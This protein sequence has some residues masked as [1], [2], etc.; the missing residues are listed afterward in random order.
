MGANESNNFYNLEQLKSIP[1]LDVCNVFGIVV[2]RKGGQLWC[3][4]RPER[5]ASAILHPENN[6]FHDFGT[7]KT[8]D[9]IGLVSV[10][11]GIDRG[12]AMRKLAEAFCISTSNPRGGLSDTELTSWEYKKIGLDGGMATKNFD[13]DLS[14]QDPSRVMELSLLYGMP[15]NVLKRQHTRIFEKLIRNRALPHIRDLR[16]DYYMEV[17]SHYNLARNMGSTGAF[18]KSVENGEFDERIKELKQAESI[19][20]RACS[21]TWIKARPVGEYEPAADIEKILAGEI[22]IPT[23]GNATYDEVKKRAEEQNTS[24]SYYTVDFDGFMNL[25]GKLDPFAHNAFLK[26]G[27]V[28]V[29]YLRKD[30]KDLKDIFSRIRIQRKENLNDKIAGAKE[31]TANTGEHSHQK[32]V[33]PSK[34]NLGEER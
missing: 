16:Q 26:D 8:S 29:Q 4:V 27:N 30:W 31:R 25:N 9:V 5:T 20:I 10:F 24:V 28:V 12:G 11:K 7:N 21:G 3:K 32:N 6:T 14:R 17:F 22:K 23:L 18:H 33:N 2:E 13:F 15:M 34:A 19:L 1:I